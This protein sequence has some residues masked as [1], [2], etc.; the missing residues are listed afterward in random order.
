M[1]ALAIGWLGSGEFEPWSEPVERWLLERS[2]NPGGS[3]LVV[4]TAAAHEGEESFSFWGRKGLEHYAALGIPAQVLP[5]RTTE[6]AYRDEVLR[7]LDDA[8]FV[9]FSGGNPA[10]LAQVVLG[11]P[12]WEALRASV[13]VGLPYGGCSAGVAC[14]TELTYDSDTQDLDA[15][16]KPGTGLVRNA[17]FGPHWDI[18]DMWIPGATDYI[19]GSVKPGQTFVGMDEDTAMVGD[20]ASWRVIGRQRIHVLADGGWRT[21]QSGDTFELPFDLAL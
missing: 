17:L 18:V 9:F 15:V 3:A 20:G 19:V 7:C 11:T 16:W 2:R 13:S 14:L 4:P 6:D 10:R 21:Y 5:L 8:S 1:S 12:F